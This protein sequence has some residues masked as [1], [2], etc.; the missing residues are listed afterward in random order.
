M[1]SL[2]TRARHRSAANEL[3]GT[4]V[5]PRPTNAALGLRAFLLLLGGL[6]SCAPRLQ[7][8]PLDPGVDFAAHAAH[9]GL[10]VDEMR[11][12]SPAVLVP[13]ALAILDG[14]SALPPAGPQ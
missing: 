1:E 12:G 14:G 4:S 13:A 11:G 2:A 3:E 10:V 5:R 7:A 8:M 9:R 6:T